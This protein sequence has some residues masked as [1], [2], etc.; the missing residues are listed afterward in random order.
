MATVRT[1]LRTELVKETNLGKRN[2]RD[3]LGEPALFGGD[4]DS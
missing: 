4:D 2:L 1:E 3:D